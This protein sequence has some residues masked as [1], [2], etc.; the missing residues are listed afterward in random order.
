LSRKLLSETI[1]E[2]MMVSAFLARALQPLFKALRY[3]ASVVRSLK[4]AKPC[5]CIFYLHHN[6]KRLS[7]MNIKTI[8]R[9]N[10]IC[11]D[12]T[13]ETMAGDYDKKTGKIRMLRPN[14][15]EKII[16]MRTA[17][18]FFTAA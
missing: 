5:R 3:S 12:H 9:I 13:E 15:K 2:K 17:R 1:I 11:Y 6:I 18:P 4:V 7:T 8:N 10:T 14:R 16:K